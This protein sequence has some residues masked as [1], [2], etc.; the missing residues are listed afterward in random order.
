MSRAFSMTVVLAALWMLLSFD[1]EPTLLAC[2]AASV[3]IVALLSFRMRLSDAEGHLVHIFLRGF[4]YWPWLLAEIAK[5]NIAVARS[6]LDRRLRITPQLITVTTGQHSDLG[7]VVYANSITLTPGTV[8]ILVGSDSI[9]VHALTAEA[10][11]GLAAGE[12]D[13]RVCRMEGEA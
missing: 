10:A 7:R 6:I 13:R 11:E 9:L 1:R 8:S 5:S 2:G 4:A 3:L 12:M